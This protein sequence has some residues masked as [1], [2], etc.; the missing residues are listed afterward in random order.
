MR[1]P[2]L[3]QRG[4]GRRPRLRRAGCPLD[5]VTI[6]AK[7]VQLDFFRHVDVGMETMQTFTTSGSCSTNLVLAGDSCGLDGHPFGGRTV[8]RRRHVV[9]RN[10]RTNDD[11]GLVM[12]AYTT[13]MGQQGDGLRQTQ[14]GT[15]NPG[16]SS[17]P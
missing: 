16:R 6:L 4:S 9:T 2:G 8:L 3:F 14:M 12:E 1:P 11:G 7:Y 10:L 13:L 15:R 5:L 17:G